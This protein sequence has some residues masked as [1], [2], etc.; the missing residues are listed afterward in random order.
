MAHQLD[1]SVTVWSES[2]EALLRLERMLQL[3]GAGELWLKRSL[4]MMAAGAGEVQ[5]V[6]LA[7]FDINWDDD[8]NGNACTCAGMFGIDPNT[9][10]PGHS[11]TCPMHHAEVWY[12]T[13]PVARRDG[14]IDY[15]VT[16]TDGDIVIHATGNTPEEAQEVAMETYERVG[17]W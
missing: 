11:W 13:K 10:G 14:S 8:D 3:P 2:P 15:S 16:L 17:A 7:G 9:P 4:Q 1:F 5:R 12:A 6:D